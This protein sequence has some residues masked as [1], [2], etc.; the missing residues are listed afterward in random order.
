MKAVLKFN[1]AVTFEGETVKEINLSGAEN[2]TSAK[3]NGILSRMRAAGVNIG[4]VP[5]NTDEFAWYAGNELTGYPVEFFSSLPVKYVK[6]MK[7][8]FLKN[9]MLTDDTLEGILEMEE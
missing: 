3:Y 7:L 6:A 4:G 8:V 2:W 1:P 9:F 5:E